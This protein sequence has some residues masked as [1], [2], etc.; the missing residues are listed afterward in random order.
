MKLKKTRKEGWREG[1]V[2]KNTN[3]VKLLGFWMLW[4]RDE[5]ESMCL[6]Y[7]SGFWFG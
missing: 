2:M 6:V 5:G 1:T 3:E 7:L 4:E